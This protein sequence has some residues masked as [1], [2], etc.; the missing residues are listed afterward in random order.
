MAYLKG[1]KVLFSPNIRVN[2]VGRLTE[3]GGE[4]FNDY[5][6]NKAVGE[7][8]SA[9]GTGT[10]ANGP[11]QSVRGKFNEVDTEGKYLDIVGNGESEENR[12]NAYALDI[13]G[14][15]YFLGKVFAGPDKES[16]VMPSEL[17][18]KVDKLNSPK[19]GYL[20]Y[21]ETPSGNTEGLECVPAATGLSIPRRGENG[22]LL[23]RDNP[24]LDNEAVSKSYVDS[25]IG[26]ALEADY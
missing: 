10:K 6:N 9:S 24:T 2:P 21:I 16:V 3:D 13:E 26:E 22:E 5:E 15:V 14:N 25:A 20:V 23:V 4:I 11:A 7:N 19:S 12:S 1:Q 18:D 8:S 17:S